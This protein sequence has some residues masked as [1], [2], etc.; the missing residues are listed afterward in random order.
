MHDAEAVGRFERSRYLCKGDEFLGVRTTRE[1]ADARAFYVF[2][3]DERGVFAAVEVEDARDVRMREL[4]GVA[5]GIAQNLPLACERGGQHPQDGYGPQMG[6]MANILP[7]DR[8]ITD[9][10]AYINT[11][12]IQGAQAA[13]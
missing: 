4:P 12:E 3:A 13:E 7:D 11:L 9:L 8:A 10:V 5:T 1:I 6:M 2:A